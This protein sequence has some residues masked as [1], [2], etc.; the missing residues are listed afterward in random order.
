MVTLAD[1]A[2]HANVSSG[3]V[4]RVL[5]NKTDYPVSG[6]TVERIRRAAAELG[7]RP[8]VMARALATGKAQAIGLCYHSITEPMF[9][10]I[11]EAAEA[12]ARE[13]GYHLIVS[14]NPE[15][16]FAG[17]IV[18]GLVYI[19][20]LSHPRVQEFARHK[21]VVFVGPSDFRGS[22]CGPN[23]VTWSEYEAAFMAVKHLAGLGH[24]TV[25]ALWGDDDPALLLRL[26]GFRA[27][28]AE[29]GLTG[30]E[31]TGEQDPDPTRRGYL[32]MERLL[33][34]EPRPTAVFARND[35]LALGALKQL[36]E[37]GV[38]VP[39]EMSVIY[40]GNSVLAR[41]AYVELSSVSHPNAEASVV[42][43]EQLI[44]MIDEGV[45][46]FPNVSLP[47]T[48]CEHDSCVSPAPSLSTSP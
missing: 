1:I 32:Q 12:K 5:N 24:R 19:G 13:R 8:N 18:D 41:A 39:R 28:V 29:F 23:T 7:Y 44:A 20:G 40:Y 15:S 34:R 37:A 4:S 25:G 31:E 33:G 2:R 27:A 47:I 36:F 38:S 48:L 35:Y 26:E 9:I 17:S 16:F 30:V 46:E 21:P 22:A 10:R 6:P 14:S 3:T 11:L 43:L 45:R 42:A